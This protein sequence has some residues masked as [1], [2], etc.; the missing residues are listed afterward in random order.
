ML[1]FFHAFFGMTA[2]EAD[3]VVESALLNNFW[4]WVVA[5]CFCLPVRQAVTDW[6]ERHI[7]P[8]GLQT[9]VALVTKLTLSAAILILSAALLVGATNNAFIY[10]RF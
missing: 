1:L 5:L 8:A 2:A 7:Q 9:T 6:T 10:T 3:F 4:L